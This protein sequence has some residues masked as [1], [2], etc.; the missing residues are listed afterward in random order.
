[1]RNVISKLL[2]VLTVFAVVGFGVY[3]FADGG[4]GYGQHRRGGD[5]PGQGWRHGGSGCPG[6]GYM[7]SDL[8]EEETQK[9]NQERRAFHKANQELEQNIYQKRLELE[10]EFAKKAPD[11]KKAAGIQKEI[12]D[13]QAQMD[14]NRVAHIL[15]MKKINPNSGR[16]FRGNGSMRGGSFHGRPCWQ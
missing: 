3:A 11:A 14:Q 15:E 12:S 5:S 1:M 10:S 13:L 4:M 9:M 6:Y 7:G 2:V 16:G 8:T